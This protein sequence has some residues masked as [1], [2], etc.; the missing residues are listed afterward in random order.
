[1]S[2]YD[3]VEETKVPFHE[4]R[5]IIDKSID[6]Y[7][8]NLSENQSLP[9]PNFEK[10]E[11]KTELSFVVT[12]PE[13]MYSLMNI[14]LSHL[15]DMKISTSFGLG[16]HLST[17]DRT[18]WIDGK[19]YSEY[20]KIRFNKKGDLSSEEIE[21]TLEAYRKGNPIVQEK[22]A[23]PKDKLIELGT[24]IYDGSLDFTWDYLAGYDDVKKEIQ[25]SVIL[26]LKHPEVYES[27]AQATR[28]VF[29]SNR[30]K[31]VL[32]EG[33]P[34]TGKTTMARIMANE[35]EVPLIYVPI[36]SIMTKWY[37]ESERNLSSI[38]D[39][40]HALGENIL[41]F[42]EID[43]LATA[44]DQNMYEATRRVLS[45]FLRK[46]DGFSPLEHSIII[47]ATNKKDDL[48]P[49]LLSRF[50]LSVPFRLPEKSERK[51][52]FE[53]YAQHL[54]PDDLEVLARESEGASGRNIKD[55]CELAERRWASKIIS[56]KEDQEIPV[57][58]EYIAAIKTKLNDF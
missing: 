32:F 55:I 49:A 9:K 42:D 26:S 13:E 44:R 11:G 24:T 33:P 12:K 25:D 28:K 48:D 21:A 5:N 2:L 30:P 57:H 35:V 16:S 46:I 27:I 52:I 15:G 43:S 14:Y 4:A 7:L 3:K 23:N 18:I 51:S 19:D 1:M 31:A 22:V 29:E 10:R 39:S 54:D 56:G 58:S 6:E 36:E 45:V 8:S 40:A 34:G 53:N 41:F 17:D 50:D 47:A 38:F 20:G 37:G